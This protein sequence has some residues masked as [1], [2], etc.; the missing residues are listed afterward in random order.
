MRSFRKSDSLVDE[1]ETVIPSSSVAVSSSSLLDG[2]AD[3]TLVA[4]Y[5]KKK[6]ME[7]IYT[8][9]KKGS[10]NL[11]DSSEVASTVAKL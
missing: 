7:A 9:Y 6:R 10:I 5:R 11:P 4:A 3:S 2:I 8:P 1:A